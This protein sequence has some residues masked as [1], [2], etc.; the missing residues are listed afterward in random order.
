M[1]A[2]GECWVTVRAGRWAVVAVALC[3][4]CISAEP[5]IRSALKSPQTHTPAPT[6]PAYTI[7]C[8]DVLEVVVANRPSLSGRYATDPSGAIGIGDVGIISVEGQT[9]A[10]AEAKIAAALGIPGNQ[11]RVAVAEYKS[12]VVFLFGSGAGAE[13]AVPF[14]GSESVVDFL[15]RTGGLAAQG[16]TDEVHVVRPQV[17]AGRRPEVFDV[18]LISILVKGD[19]TSDVLL[20]AY[21]QVYV[22]ATRR[23]VYAHYLPGGE[24]DK[25]PAR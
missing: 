22:G 4:G 6:A 10:A 24:W 19:R 7:S 18:D 23:S 2:I 15:R 12:R 14:Q 3:A 17:A 1:V 16:N 13:R 8:P 21:D 5:R 9:P 20:Q 25:S 11:V